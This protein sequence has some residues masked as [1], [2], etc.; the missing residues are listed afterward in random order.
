MTPTVLY[1]Y[2]VHIKLPCKFFKIMWE[3]E[4]LDNKNKQFKSGR[5]IR[6]IKTFRRI[7]GQ[8]WPP[9]VVDIVCPLK[10]LFYLL[11]VIS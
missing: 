7:T 2:K 8:V 5:K 11:L 10:Q 9:S 1:F 4:I 3:S 6:K